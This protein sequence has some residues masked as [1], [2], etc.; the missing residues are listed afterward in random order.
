M[1]KPWVEARKK[2]IKLTKFRI[3]HHEKHGNGK[4]AEE[5]K[6]QLLRQQKHSKDME[7]K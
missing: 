6:R 5:E 2:G 3:A 7:D 1:V 4:V